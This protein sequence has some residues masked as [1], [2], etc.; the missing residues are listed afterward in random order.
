VLGLGYATPQA[1][2]SRRASM[3]RTSAPVGSP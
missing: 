3:R 2:S 1:S